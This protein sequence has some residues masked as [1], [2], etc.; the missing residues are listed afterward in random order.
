MT[1]PCTGTGFFSSS[2]EANW[3]KI[4]SVNLRVKLVSQLLELAQHFFAPFCHRVLI[5][6]DIF[7]G[8]RG[9][10]L[11]SKK[12]CF[13]L[14]F[15]FCFTFHLI[16]ENQDSCRYFAKHHCSQIISQSQ[17]SLGLPEEWPIR[18][19]I[20]GKSAKLVR[21]LVCTLV[22]FS[23]DNVLQFTFSVE[24]ERLLLH[25]RRRPWQK[26]LWTQLP[27][28]RFKRAR[29]HLILIFLR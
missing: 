6:P 17:T 26:Q 15:F 18:R 21:K 19:K 10:A 11:E 27:F 4:P 25:Q 29:W 12:F 7:E 9:R 14:S 24:K 5:H 16:G 3:A 20:E 1:T 28:L 8:A 2:V 23:H 22:I 13:S